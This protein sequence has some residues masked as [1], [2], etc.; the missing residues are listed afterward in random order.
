MLE[1]GGGAKWFRVCVASRVNTV[2][3]KKCNSLDNYKC[4]SKHHMSCMHFDRDTV[5][6]RQGETTPKKETSEDQSSMITRC[7]QLCMSVAGG[8]SC[9]KMVL[10][11]VYPQGR[12]DL[13][14]RTYAIIDDQANKTRRRWLL[15]GTWS[16]LWFAGVRECPPWHSIVGATVTVHQFLYFTFSCAKFLRFVQ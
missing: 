10:V 11:R 8:R 16:H 9:G 13:A 6:S 5:H 14:I 7:S 1:K 2:M 12:L 3:A 4:G 15:P